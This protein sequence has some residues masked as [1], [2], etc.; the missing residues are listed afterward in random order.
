M[1]RFFYDP[2]TKD[3]NTTEA[4]TPDANTKDALKIGATFPLTPDIFQHWVKVL[5]AQV[6]EQA[7]WFDGTGG[8]YRVTLSQIQ[9][10][11]ATV[12]VDE[13][14]AIDRTLPFDVD[15]AL[16]MSRGERM[17]YAIQKATEAG[18]R[19]IQLLT[20]Q[21]G[22]VRLK[23]EQIPKKLAHWQQVAI[24]ACEQCGLNRV[25]K[26]L[27]PLAL[28]DWLAISPS[29]HAHALKLVLAVPSAEGDTTAHATPRLIV[30]QFCQSSDPLI[31]AQ[32]CL[33][34]GAEGGLSAQ[35]VQ[36][37]L[38]IGFHPWQIGT[39][40]LRTETAPVVALAALATWYEAAQ[41][42]KFTTT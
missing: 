32:F 8:E 4:N 14:F 16:V 29:Y 33:L 10:N 13:F 11:A 41:I 6:G 35:E 39:R 12:H 20:S 28:A 25:P 27:P 19:R 23:P 37:A 34:I 17:D 30:Q 38:A 40:V 2:T 5:R 42:G 15:V 31:A 22:E 36:A 3:A 21:H 1:R 18:V 26:I 24:A 9:K 7:L